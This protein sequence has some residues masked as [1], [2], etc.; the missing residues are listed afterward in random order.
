MVCL[1]TLVQKRS[2]NQ[3]PTEPNLYSLQLM[4]NS[5]YMK[6]AKVALKKGKLAHMQH[7]ILRVNC[8]D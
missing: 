2:Y 8:I 4:N 6:R 1:D 5:N 7:L 3:I